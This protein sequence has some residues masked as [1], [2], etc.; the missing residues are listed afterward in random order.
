MSNDEESSPPGKS[1]VDKARD[2]SRE[3]GWTTVFAVVRAI[4]RGLLSR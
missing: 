1:I 2:W 3:W 4:I